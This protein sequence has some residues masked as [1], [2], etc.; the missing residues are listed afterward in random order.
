MAN[1]SLSDDTLAPDAA[2]SECAGMSRVLVCLDR[3]ELSETVL[4]YAVMLARAIGGSLTLMNIAE[5]SG[6]I[7]SD[8]H[9]A[10]V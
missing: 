8:S 2:P 5:S 1:H 9:D 3:S 4:S 6:D 7:T 10:L